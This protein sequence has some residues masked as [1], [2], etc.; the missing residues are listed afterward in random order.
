MDLRDLNYFM[1]I[2]QLGHLGQAAAQLNRSQPALSKSLQRLEEGLGA[3]LFL[4]E[5]R[6]IKLTEVGELLLH[7][8]RQ[9]QMTVA[10]TEREVRDL[11]QGLVG[12]IR[13]GCAASMADYL[14]PQLTAALLER[15]PKL[16][17]TLSIAQDDVLTEALQLGRLDAIIS[18]KIAERSLFTFYPVLQDQAVVVA[19]AEHP[20][21]CAPLSLEVLTTYRWVLPARK[22]AARQ[23][24][25]SVFLSHG[26]P[27]PIVQIETNAVSL[28]PR[29]IDRTQLLSFIARKTLER[30]QGMCRLREVQLEE[31][32][33][34][35]TVAVA[36]RAGSYLSPAART[37]IELLEQ[38]ALSFPD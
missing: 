16:T 22:V 15:A 30:G 3:R 14:L 17:L 21:F 5:G 19:S 6:G 8:G 24:L 2:A 37:M 31:T 20:L 28:L 1:V 9:L 32:T 13:I 10:E 12:N 4:R 26:L 25:D 35:R 34:C 36:V 38:L 7:R 29:L 18:P 23:W 33:R 11:A 27:P